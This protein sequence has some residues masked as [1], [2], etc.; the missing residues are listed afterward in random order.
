VRAAQA[1]LPERVPRT[2]VVY[3]DGLGKQADSIHYDTAGQL[4]LGKRF[5]RAYSALAS[6]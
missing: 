5:A 3:T 1:A 2:A 6:P 4:E